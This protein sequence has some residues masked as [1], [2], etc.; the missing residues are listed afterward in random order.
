MCRD[1][2]Y[3]F[4]DQYNSEF[5]RCLHP[6]KGGY[7]DNYYMQMA[8]NIRKYKGIRPIPEVRGAR[9]IAIDGKFEDWATTKVEYLDTIGDT[10]HRDYDGYGGLHFKN[11]SGRNDIVASKVAASTDTVSFYVRT[12]EAITP[13]TGSNWMLLLIDADCSAK[14]GWFG[15]DFLVNQRVTDDRTTTIM[16]Y[17]GGQWVE[18]GTVAY[19][20]VGDQMELQI[21]R[22]LLGLKRGAVTFDFKW[23]DNPTDLKDPISLCTDG[24]TAPNRRFNY[25]C[26]WKP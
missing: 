25:R 13:H 19:R 14:T 12:R 2:S 4:V 1:S 9:R 23:T 6:M 21:P 3:F 5:N 10:F 20:C 22:K 15:Y 7:T 18:A 26:I 24:D 8:Q 16:R 11:D 17:A